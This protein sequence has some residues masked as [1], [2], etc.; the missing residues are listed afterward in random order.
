[1]F[2]LAKVFRNGERAAT[3]HPEFTLLEWYR[4]EP[5][6]ERLFEDCEGMLRAVAKAAGVRHLH[7]QGRS[8][9]PFKA[10]ERLSVSDAFRRYADESP[11]RRS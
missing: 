11:E 3:H 6:M 2:T 7:W 10:F 4:A 8:V 1:M 9:D 5:E